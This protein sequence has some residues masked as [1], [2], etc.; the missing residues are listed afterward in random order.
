MK[1]KMN[2][3]LKDGLVGVAIGTAV[4]VPGVSGGTIA[5]IFGAFKKIV[6]AVSEL[7]SKNFWKGLVALIPFGIGAILAVAALIFPFQL[8]FEYCMFSIICLFAGFIVG[9][10][11]GLNDQIKEKEA[12]TRETFL[13]IAGFLFAALIGILSVF[14]D[15]SGSI[16]E[17]FSEVPFYL[18]FI[19]F[20]VGIIGSTGLIVPGFS[21][22]MLLLVIGFY[23]PILDLVSIENLGINISLL[24]TFAVGVIIGFVIFSKI[25]NYFI[26]AHKRSTMFVVIGFVTGS[27]VSIF[28]NSELF[29]YFSTTFGLLDIILGPILLA[30]G[31]GLSLTLT[32]YIRR[33]PE[34]QNAKN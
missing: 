31:I 26:T 13:M 14:F 15:F 32:F 17:L 20:A 6:N 22:S 21:G 5:L 1:K 4:I 30:V 24:A 11:P 7:F 9:S 25:M 16:S 28:I 2:E 19:I 3:P 8:A 34:L 18:Y 10:I 29:S 33:H 12:S 23:R 27:L